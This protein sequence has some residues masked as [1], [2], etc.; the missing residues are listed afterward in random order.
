MIPGFRTLVS[1]PA[2]AVKMPLRKF[3]AYT[4][5]GCLVWNAFLVHIGV[6]LG[7]N[8]REVAGV[9]RYLII[10]VLAAILVVLVVFLIRRRKRT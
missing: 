5:G 1:F 2:G 3:A 6:Y 4:T 9:S 7:S 8:W 10:G